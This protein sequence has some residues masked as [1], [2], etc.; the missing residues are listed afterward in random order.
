[1]D[2]PPHV[3]TTK[4]RKSAPCNASSLVVLDNL[5]RIIF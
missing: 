5:Q 3:G 2:A 4:T 1:M